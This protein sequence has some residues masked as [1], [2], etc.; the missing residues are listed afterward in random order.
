MNKW[1]WVHC[2]EHGRRPNRE[3][4]MCQITASVNRQQ[5]RHLPQH[6]K[7]ADIPLSPW[8]VRAANGRWHGSKDI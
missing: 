7:P 8:E 3:H 1:I 5:L 2:P 4:P 6:V